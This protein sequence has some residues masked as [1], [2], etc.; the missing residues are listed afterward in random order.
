MQFPT[1]PRTHHLPFLTAFGLAALLSGCAARTAAPPPTTTLNDLHP[2]A[3]RTEVINRFGPP[4]STRTD[5]DGTA[6]DVYKFVQG[7]EAHDT[8]P[9]DTAAVEATAQSGPSVT[10]AMAQ[11]G[12]ITDPLFKGDT[13]TVQVTYDEDDTVEDTALLNVTPEKNSPPPP[14][15]APAP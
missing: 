9:A 14:P 4:V 11:T 2:G 1:T 10:A 6:T 8:S 3:E 5:G 12:P 13:L 15:P 7:G